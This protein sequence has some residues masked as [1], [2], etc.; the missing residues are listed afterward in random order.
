VGTFAFVNL[1]RFCWVGNLRQNANCEIVD[2]Y[3]SFNKNSQLLEA[4]RYSTQGSDIYSTYYKIAHL[5]VNDRVLDS[6]LKIR[7]LNTSIFLL[8]LY[9]LLSGLNKIGYMFVTIFISIPL[10]SYTITSIHNLSWT[11]TGIFIL[12]LSHLIST[13]STEIWKILMI[14]FMGIILLLFSREENLLLVFIYVLWFFIS[15]SKLHKVI[16]LLNKILILFLFFTFTFKFIIYLPGFDNLVFSKF[17]SHFWLLFGLTGW[18][19]PLGNW[20]IGWAGDYNIPMVSVALLSVSYLYLFFKLIYWK[21][22]F[23]SIFGISIYIFLISSLSPYTTLYF[24]PRHILPISI[25]LFSLSLIQ[26]RHNILVSNFRILIS[27]IFIF[28]GN[29][30]N[31]YSLLYRFVFGDAMTQSQLKSLFLPIDPTLNWWWGIPLPPGFFLLMNLSS[32][33]V[34]SY[35]TYTSIKGKVILRETIER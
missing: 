3:Y 30:L 28:L 21:H 5:F 4:S 34:V 18:S 12:I 22:L 33:G 15:H 9:F 20:G 6:V 31:T 35:I 8:S 27:F 16:K 10:I 32:L 14:R 1:N 13:S 24:L 23:V 25:L 19:G 2:P 11:L 7:L 29:S 26:N 17:I